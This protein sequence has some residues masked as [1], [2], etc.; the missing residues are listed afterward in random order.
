[1]KRLASLLVILASCGSPPPPAPAAPRAGTQ[2]GG[3]EHGMANCPAALA[4]AVTRVTDIADGVA[5]TITATDPISRERLVALGEVHD[6]MR[7]PVRTQAEHTGMHGGPGD[8]GHCPIIHNRT[9]VTVTQIPGGIY[10]TVRAWDPAELA[11]L[12]ADTRA[13]VDRLPGWLVTQ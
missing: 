9:A 6:Q 2:T 13:R 1:M 7:D 8:R 12:R 4:T 11:Q 5:L 3:L 10:V